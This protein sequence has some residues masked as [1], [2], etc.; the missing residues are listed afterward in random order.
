MAISFNTEYYLEQK[1]AQLQANGETAFTSTDDV[2]QAL[3]NSGLTAEEHYEQFG[4]SEGLNPNADFNTTVYLNLKLAQLQADGETGFNSIDDVL[5]AFDAAGLSPLEHYNQFGVAEALSPNASFNAQAY[6]EDKLALLQSQN[7]E[8]FNTIAD[9]MAAFQNAGLSPLEHFQQ[10]G[11]SEGLTAKP[12]PVST[13]GLTAALEDLQAANTAK[14]SFLAEN[15]TTEEAI[16]NNL[17]TAEQTLVEA[18][19]QTSGN[20]LN[21]N[22]TNSENLVEAAEADIAAVDGLSDAIATLESAK[23][24]EEEAEQA[25]SSAMT[26]FFAQQTSFEQLHQNATFDEDGV[27]VE[28][29]L[30]LQFDEENSTLIITEAG[31]GLEGINALVAAFEATVAAQQDVEAATTTVEQAQA[32]VNPLDLTLSAVAEKAE[33]DE[34]QAALDA[35]ISANGTTE[36]LQQS[37]TTAETDRAQLQGEIDSAETAVATA[38][39]E[40]DSA[41]SARD[42]AQTTLADAT[43]AVSAAQGELLSAED[44]RDSAQTTLDNAENQQ[45]QAQSA[46]GAAQ[47]QVTTAQTNV[48]DANAAVDIAQTELDTATGNVTTASDNL[49]NAQQAE[50]TA[51]A[52]VDSF[53]LLVDAYNTAL[54]NYS[55]GDTA[56]ETAL[57]DAYSALESDSVANLPLANNASEIAA[58]DGEIQTAITT[59]TG[60]LAQSLANAEAEVG[61]AEAALLTAEA[62]ETAAQTT[63]ANAQGELTV[64]QTELDEA[65]QT[66]TQAQADLTTA[67]DAVDA[68]QSAF[69]LAD[70]NVVSAQTT[71]SKAQDGAGVAQAAFDEAAAAATEAQAELVTAQS[72]LTAAQE[73]GQA[74]TEL[75]QQIAAVDEVLATREEL[76]T[77]AE[78]TQADFEAAVSVNPLYQ[79]LLDARD[80]LTAAQGALEARNELISDVEEAQQLEA[81]LAELN[82]TIDQAQAWFAEQDLALPVS[83]DVDR[84]GTEDGDIFLFVENASGAFTITG[85][86]EEGQDTLYFGNNF[87]LVSLAEQ[88]EAGLAITDRV[89]NNDTLEIFWAQDGDDLQLYVEADSAAGFDRGSLATDQM[90][91]ITLKNFSADN[92]ADFDGQSLITG[93]APVTEEIIA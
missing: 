23:Q 41:E 31:E 77:T 21:V 34:A 58:A 61:T 55:A 48:G 76:V 86:G 16:S 7:V 89:G 74:I 4:A 71:L 35:H 17:T 53:Q 13:L 37:R 91:Q 81:E 36:A 11:Q 52:N 85:F 49:I 8:G 40:F 5:A 12:L 51:Q 62:N 90:T 14:E 79:E 39:S 42:A 19:A 78:N 54:A 68:A 29:Q 18:R 64:A 57:E 33:R 75:E 45:A 6:L 43:A 60:D 87:S 93:V 47:S 84:A 20:R 10:Y 28:G 38:Q 26:T 25:L 2:A 80:A 32:T 46:L 72:E 1:L 73:A 56:T 9:V 22:V 44:I 92:I 69:A 83:L 24:A 30:V 67:Y 50:I 59:E 3:A 66:Q 82:A 88:G 27:S 15:K 63:L 70:A 65:Q